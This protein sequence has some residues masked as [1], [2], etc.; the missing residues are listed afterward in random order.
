MTFPFRGGCICGAIR[1]ECSAEPI[2]MFRCHCR[3][4]QHISGG[5]YSA[6]V[7]V[8]KDSFK[9]TKGS[10]QHFPTRSAAGG[11]NL[12]GFCAACG[13]R[14]SGGETDLAIGVVAGSLDDPS[15]FQAAM[16][17]HV[18][19]AQPWDRLDADVPKF[20]QYPPGA[21]DQS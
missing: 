8:P 20:E 13:S 3:D 16:D 17:I 7:Y 15:W 12:R 2:V 21:Q 4:C 9:F 19:D 18:A 10:V 11:E 14:I 5:P 6:V 1:Y